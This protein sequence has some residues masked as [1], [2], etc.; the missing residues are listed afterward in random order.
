M[1]KPLTRFIENFLT[2]LAV[3]MAASALPLAF[4]YFD[5]S[6]LQPI[7][8]EINNLN[9]KLDILK[10]ENKEQSDKICELNN[11]TGIE[12]TGCGTYIW[13]KKNEEKI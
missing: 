2:G 12:K 3:T 8:G 9:S 6:Y 13:R 4:L 10:K 1:K 11:K 7:R 5:N